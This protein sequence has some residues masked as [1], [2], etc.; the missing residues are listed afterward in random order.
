MFNFSFGS[1]TG[2]GFADTVDWPGSAGGHQLGWEA[3]GQRNRLYQKTLT[4]APPWSGN[5]KA[6]TG[7]TWNT[8]RASGSSGS[9]APAYRSGAETPVLSDAHVPLRKE[10]TA[11]I[12]QVLRPEGRDENERPPSE[13]AIGSRG[14]LS[15]SKFPHRAGASCGTRPGSAPRAAPAHPWSKRTY[16]RRAADG[17][18]QVAATSFSSGLGLECRLWLSLQLLLLTKHPKCWLPFYVV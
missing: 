8:C 18:G 5:S 1:E 3:R 4:S 14:G 16:R 6:S 17:P 12:P 13:R 2:R 9:S 15:L 7:H 10:A 11:D